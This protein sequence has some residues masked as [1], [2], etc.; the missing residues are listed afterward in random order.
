MQV[1]IFIGDIADAPAEGLCTSTNP[2][3][4]LVMG[5]GAAIRE[6]GGFSIARECETIVGNT[7]LPVGSAHV[8]GAGDLPA[9][10]I[11]HCVASD[12]HHRSSAA[13]VRA[14]VINALQRADEKG[15]R[16]VAMPVFATGHA[17]VSFAKALQAMREALDAANTNVEQVVVVVQDPDR[18]EET[19]HVLC[20]RPVS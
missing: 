6:R 1:S 4:S 17:H 15:C 3:L 16:M 7:P 12:V 13:I 8:T 18:E 20:T 5:T 11:I 2:R 10:A 9:K 19:R 14:C